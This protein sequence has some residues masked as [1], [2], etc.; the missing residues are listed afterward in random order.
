MVWIDQKDVVAQHL[1]LATEALGR[2]EADASVSRDVVETLAQL[3]AMSV[4]LA[5]LAGVGIAD[6]APP[7]T[8]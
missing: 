2:A 3:R 6:D 1:A 4:A 5:K 7:T 8:R